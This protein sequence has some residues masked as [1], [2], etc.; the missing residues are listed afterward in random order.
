VDY[1]DRSYFITVDRRR[2][3]DDRG[4]DT[5]DEAK[6]EANRRAKAQ[7]YDDNGVKHAISIPGYRRPTK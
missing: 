4:F 1:D 6:D 5:Y 3:G 2:L 7:G